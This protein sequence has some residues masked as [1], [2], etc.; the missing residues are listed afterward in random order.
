[1]RFSSCSI[2]QYVPHP[3]GNTLNNNGST[4]SYGFDGV[5]QVS[6]SACCTGVLQLHW[7]I[8]VF[9]R[10]G[11]D[12]KS[13]YAS[14]TAAQACVAGAFFC[15]MFGGRR[16]LGFSAEMYEKA[17][18]DKAGW[19]HQTPTCRRPSFRRRAGTDALPER[20]ILNFYLGLVHGQ[21]MRIMVTMCM[22][23]GPK[24]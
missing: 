10:R 11:V 17:S 18:G 8:S 24:L 6:I 12:F 5:R 4:S 2:F 21:E 23:P 14:P 3:S 9:G 1:M 19:L 7:W 13:D 22:T 15:H 16:I 20:V